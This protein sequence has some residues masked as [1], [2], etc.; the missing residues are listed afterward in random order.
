MHQSPNLAIAL[1]PLVLILAAIA[2]AL[3]YVRRQ[4]YSGPNGRTIV[5]CRDGHL[6]TTIWVPLVSFK[7]VR[8]GMTRFQYCPVGDHWSF[9][10]PVKDSDL[11]DAERRLASEYQDTQI[12]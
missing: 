6:Y 7:S 8:L 10:V 11:T 12:P 9:V 4:G 1:L 3:I 5:R 2:L